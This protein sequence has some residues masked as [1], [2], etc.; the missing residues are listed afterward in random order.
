MAT[1]CK[2]CSKKLTNTRCQYCTYCRDS[3]VNIRKRKIKELY[4]A[5][6]RVK[7]HNVRKE[8]RGFITAKQWLALLYRCDK[9]CL[10]C[11]SKRRIEMDHVIPLSQ[12]GMN[13]ITNIQPLCKKC[14]R[15]KHTKIADYRSQELIEF[16]FGLKEK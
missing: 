13:L 4:K 16:L 5:T 2:D 3:R 7:F 15:S 6:R 1:H 11:G 9:K 12:G 8:E 10:A 14:N